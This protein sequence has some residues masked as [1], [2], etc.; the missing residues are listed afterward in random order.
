[1]INLIISFCFWVT[2]GKDKWIFYGD[3]LGYYTYLPA[4]FN[5][6]KLLTI[7]EISKD[8]NVPKIVRDYISNLNESSEINKTPPVIQYTYVNSLLNSPAFFL[9]KTET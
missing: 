7:S 8:T 6:N 4:T 2:Y 9:V 5:Y 1:M 3:A